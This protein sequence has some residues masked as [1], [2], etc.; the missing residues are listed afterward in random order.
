MK[1]I[2]KYSRKVN[3]IKTKKQVLMRAYHLQ[4]EFK[5]LITEQEKQDQINGKDN[6]S[7]NDQKTNSDIYKIMV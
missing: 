4:N 1:Q 5:S 3:K 2:I 7:V 6:K